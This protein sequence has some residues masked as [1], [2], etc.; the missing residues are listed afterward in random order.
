MFSNRNQTSQNSQRILEPFPQ[1]ERLL[2]GTSHTY[3]IRVHGQ[4]QMNKDWYIGSPQCQATPTTLRT[5]TLLNS[6]TPRATTPFLLLLGGGEGALS[7]KL[8]N[9]KPER[10]S[11]LPTRAFLQR[12]KAPDSFCSALQDQCFQ[13][14]I[15]L[16]R[17]HKEF[18]NL[19]PKR[20][21]FWMA[22]A[23]LIPSEFTA[24]PRW[25]KIGI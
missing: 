22:P 8:R 14:E 12:F 11:S 6:Y 9:K 25:T 10:F 13:I 4:T 2:N 20:S 1:K 18:W 5:S 24:K 21:D 19:S 17:I 15:K 3:T 7:R 16:L 23:I